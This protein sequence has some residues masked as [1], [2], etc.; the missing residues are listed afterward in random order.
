MDDFDTP[1]EQTTLLERADVRWGLGS[2]QAATLVFVT[3]VYLDHLFWVD[4]AVF[5][6]G[7][8]VG[9]VLL[10]SALKDIAEGRRKKYND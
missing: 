2:L 10:P 8:A 3:Y 1:N 7:A 6:L 5:Y 9:F 4:Q